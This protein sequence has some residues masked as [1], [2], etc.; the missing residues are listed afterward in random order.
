VAGR[1]GGLALALLLA[2]LPCLARGAAAQAGG[3]PAGGAD[4]A[5]AQAG[6]F[7]GIG[8]A[9]IGALPVIAQMNRRDEAFRQYIAD[10]E[11]NRRL[12]FSRGRRQGATA[13]AIAEALT[14]FKYV[15]REGDDLLSLAARSSMPVSALASLN[16]LGNGADLRPGMALLLPSAPGIFVPAEPESDLER[17]LASARL[18][19]Y[20]G[21][22]L[23]VFVPGPSGSAEFLFFPGDE[24]TQA[25]R[26]FFL[27]PGFFRFPLRSFRVTSGYGMRACPLGGRAH[28]HR[29]IDLAA[30][31]GTEI[32]AAADGVV[33][34]TGYDRVLGYF[35]RIR[36]A[37]NWISL[38][39]HMQRIGTAPGAEVRSGSL[40]GWVGST[41]Q[42]TG[43]HLHFELW[44]GDRTR[45]P[46]RYLRR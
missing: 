8:A 16:R 1:C 32:F 41:G 39:G 7:G 6:G 30:P 27:N 26:A 43:P 23:T 21:D 10:V 35:V 34:E 19:A 38:Y 15:A 40:I 25:E 9:G 17:L 18:P 12:V 31:M 11:A 46:S 14:I 42:S 4:S 22:A 36:H 44:Q 20:G 13:E 45:D 3:A 5:G 28:F 37:R 2:L 29:G 33:A 24:F